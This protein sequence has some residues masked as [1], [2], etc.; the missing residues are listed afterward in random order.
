MKKIFRQVTLIKV[1]IPYKFSAT[2]NIPAN[3]I[4]PSRQ[5]LNF[6]IKNY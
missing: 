4:A 5:V 6:K 2:K 1:D 3:Q